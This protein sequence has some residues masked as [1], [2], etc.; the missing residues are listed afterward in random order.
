MK[1]SIIYLGIT[2]FSFVNVSS[3]VNNLNIES[4][5][6][7]ENALESEENQLKVSLSSINDFLAS[8]DYASSTEE[9]VFNPKTVISEISTTSIEE[10]IKADNEIIESNISSSGELLYIEK[11]MEEVIAADNEIIESNLDNELRPIYLERTIEDYIE[12]NN[13]II[14]SDTSDD[15]QPLDFKK[16]DENLFDV[17]PFT[18]EKVID[19]NQ[20]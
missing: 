12:E 14:E 15:F 6:A 5:F 9:V 3:A 18:K 2:L 10:V 11:S 1:N 17:K 13:A 20:L 8:K 4:K 16:I 7:Q 19:M